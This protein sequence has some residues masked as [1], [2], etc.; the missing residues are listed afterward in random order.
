M[1]DFLKQY[2]EL[3]VGAQLKLESNIY[4]SCKCTITLTTK[5]LA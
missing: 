3:E 2:L 5:D 4:T 1:I